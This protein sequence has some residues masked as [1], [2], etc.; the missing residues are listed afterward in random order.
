MNDVSSILPVD[1]E[2]SENSY[3]KT[4]LDTDAAALQITRRYFKWDD[5]IGGNILGEAATVTYGYSAIYDA[6]NTALNPAMMAV[7]DES[8]LAIE[9]V[10]N[11]D[12]T[13]IGSGTSGIGA[14]TDAAEM[15]I[16]AIPGYGGGY[17][18]WGY[19]YG[20]SGTP[21]ELSG[22]RVAIGA[23]A[24][25]I[26]DEDYGTS[27][28]LHEIAHAVGLLHPGD[29][30]GA[31]VTNYESQAE[32]FED[33]GQ[34]SVMSYRS[35]TKTGADFFCICIHRIF[36]RICWRLR[37]QFNVARYCRFAAFV[38]FEY[39]YSNRGYSLWLQLQYK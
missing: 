6:G 27:L 29:Y 19:T 13:R 5:G 33:S 7:V 39:E 38:R 34:Y 12:F 8:I 37:Y 1:V 20:G 22:A 31:G 11:L 10:A 3:G 36:L 2:A 23:T 14:F 15:D 17:A 9:E 24:G 26:Y 32:Y 30:N 18:S 16:E 4:S 28:T 35:E 25:Y 21:D